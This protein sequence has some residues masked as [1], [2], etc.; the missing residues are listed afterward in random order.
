MDSLFFQI[1]Y[2]FRILVMMLFRNFMAIY[3]RRTKILRTKTP[4]AFS[5]QQCK[6][7]GEIEN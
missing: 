4:F 7:E 6:G 1:I 2:Q 3:G 5:F